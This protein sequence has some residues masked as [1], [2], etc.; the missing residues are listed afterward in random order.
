MSH[1]NLPLNFERIRPISPRLLDPAGDID[2]ERGV[3]DRQRPADRFDAGELRDPRIGHH[4]QRGE[5]GFGHPVENLA[6]VLVADRAHGDAAR[7]HL[8]LHLRHRGHHVGELRTAERA[9]QHR[10]VVGIDHV[11]EMLQPV[12]GNDGRAAAADRAVVGLDELAV[13]HLF[14]AFVAR[15]H[16]LF[17]GRS[18]I[19][20][21]Q[22]VA[23]L[24]G[25]Q[26]WRTL[27]L[28]WPPSGSQGCSRQW[29]SVSNF[30]P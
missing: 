13:V 16:R 27:S 5:G 11:L 9:V 6:V 22:P 1:Q 17:L 2:A 20:E 25:Y 12:A 7:R 8:E 18:H 30:Q 21:D 23:F 19:G 26:G 10:H 29:P 28:N 14:Q 24:T 3:V 15:Q 4:A